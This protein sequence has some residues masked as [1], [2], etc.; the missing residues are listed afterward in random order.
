MST[1]IGEVNI[2]LRMSLAQFK[3]DTA[4]GT[5]AAS[6]SVKDMGESIKGETHE[7]REAFQLLG[8]QI[9]VRLP[10]GITNFL[11]TL[12]GVGSAMSAAFSGVAIIGL[13]AVIEEGAEKLDKFLESLTNLSE[14][15]KSAL[16]D[17]TTELQKSIEF[18][19]QMQTIRRDT[20]LIG[21]TEV[22]QA[23]LRAL[24][25][26]EDADS[27]QK[28]YERTLK[29]Y[30]AAKAIVAL[31]GK[32]THS[33]NTFKGQVV[34]V[35]TPLVTNDK[36]KDAK[37]LIQ[38]LENQYG[39]DLE[40]LS[41]SVDVTNANAALAAAKGSAEAQAAYKKQMEDSEKQL[42][43]I[44]DAVFKLQSRLG[45]PATLQ[46]IAKV[47]PQLFEVQAM[48]DK[49]ATAPPLPIYSGTKEAEDAYKLTHDQATQIAE[50]QKVY[51]ATRTGAIR[52]RVFSCS[53]VTVFTTL[54]TACSSRRR[55]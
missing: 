28:N 9:G 11:T 45:V 17:I 32:T 16:R 22:E 2:N 23:Q 25:S 53:S 52:R 21:K 33:T 19:K 3:Q 4:D 31:E 10:R 48:L 41:R 5:K 44:S 50:A 14:E 35:D 39:K 36:I 29:L 38:S 13:L 12:R 42:T 34:D 37:A 46:I 27:T 43:K 6:K 18:A 20:S 40:D 8:E 51:T 1:T 26:A 49:L 7:A 15:E 47:D 30:D 24:W 55:F 54:W